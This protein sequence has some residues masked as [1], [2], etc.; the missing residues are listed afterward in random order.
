MCNYL[1]RLGWAH[2]DDEI[3]S[4]DQMT[5]WFDLDAINKGAAR[6]DFA[7]LAN[8]NGIYIRNADPARL[9]DIML[10]NA[11][12]TERDVDVAGLTAEKDKVLRALPELQP[13]AKIIPELIDLAQ[14]IYVTR[15]LSFDEKA[16]GQLTDESRAML[17]EVT[18]LLSAATD[19]TADALGAVVRDYAEARDLKLGKIAQPLRAALT[20]RTVSPG[21]FEVMELLG[22]EE[23]LARLGDQR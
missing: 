22:R 6:F 20:G 8:I 13:R 1:A 5:E 19:W 23:S 16:A 3:F 2:G 17:G 14:F 12:E 15:P 7:K 21:V 11:V 9:Y 18:D 10:A 4:M